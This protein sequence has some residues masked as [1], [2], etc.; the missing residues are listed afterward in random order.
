MKMNKSDHSH[1]VRETHGHGHETTAKRKK[2][3]FSYLKFIPMIM[4]PLVLL[5]AA[6]VIMLSLIHI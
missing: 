1:D 5:L 6:F 4:I 3:I 2:S